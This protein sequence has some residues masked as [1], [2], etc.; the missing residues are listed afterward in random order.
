MEK[1][2]AWKELT[3]FIDSYPIGSIISRKMIMVYFKGE[4]VTEGTLDKNRCW[5]TEA[6]Y[7]EYHT[8]GLYKIIRKIGTLTSSDCEKEAYPHRFK[9]EK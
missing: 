4:N 6:G 8:L 3:K 7:L 9:K 5:L 1:Y 2:N